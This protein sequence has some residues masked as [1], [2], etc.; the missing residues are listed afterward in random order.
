MLTAKVI[1]FLVKKVAENRRT[2]R[3]KVRVNFQL[4]ITKMTRT[5][6]GVKLMQTDDILYF[7]NSLQVSLFLLALRLFL[8]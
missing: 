5:V 7:C 1:S 3:V 2:T 4:L 6:K 8:A